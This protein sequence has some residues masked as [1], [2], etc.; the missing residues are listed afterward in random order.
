M[1]CDV[2][3]TSLKKQVFRFSELPSSIMSADV[4]H[5]STGYKEKYKCRICE[6]EPMFAHSCNTAA[7][8]KID[9]V[10][11]KNTDVT[12][13]MVRFIGLLLCFIKIWLFALVC[14]HTEVYF[15]RWAGIDKQREQ[16]IAKKCSGD[17]L[18]S[19]LDG[20]ES[21]S[22]AARAKS[23]PWRT[24]TIFKGTLSNA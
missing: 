17:F 20:H 10:I 14:I 4:S 3:S 9:Y 22:R 6:I 13:S 19:K 2:S 24:T 5:F 11:W 18:L 21:V 8:T 23:C 12:C 7:L 1:N 15:Y 16:S